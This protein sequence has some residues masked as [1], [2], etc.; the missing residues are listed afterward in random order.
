MQWSCCVFEGTVFARKWNGIAWEDMGSSSSSGMGISEATRAD[1]ICTVRDAQNRPTV[2]YNEGWLYAVTFDGAAWRELPGTAHEGGFGSGTSDAVRPTLVLDANGW[3]LVFWEQGSPAADIHG[4][5]FD[6]TAWVGLG[7]ADDTN[8]SNTAGISE[9]P[10]AALDTQ[11][12]VVLAWDEKIG[13][14]GRKVFVKRWS[15]GVW[16]ELGGSATGDGVSG[17]FNSAWRPALALLGNDQP[18]V[19]WEDESIVAKVWRDP[20]WEP[21]DGAEGDGSIAVGYA[22]TVVA[23]DATRLAFAWENPT[24]DISGVMW[25]GST[26][27][28]LSP[29][30]RDPGIL[31]TSGASTSPQLALD[32]R[33]RVVLVWSDEILHASEIHALALE[34]SGWVEWSSPDMPFGNVSGTTDASTTPVLALD[35]RRRPMVAWAD[36]ST[37]NAN[38][39]IYV[40]RYNGQRWVEVGEGSASGGGVSNSACTSAHPAIAT[41][42]GRVCVAWNECG[43]DAQ[44]V[45]LRCAT[46]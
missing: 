31:V 30:S 15:A 34:G 38:A 21:L 24:D 9:E 20:L 17:A 3:P 14:E 19:V 10:V 25:T 29:G 36:N 12:R 27:A 35:D 13:T 18:V 2:L 40:R 42:S 8:I 28:D 33:G 45:V 23:M 4:S 11:G 39:D 22:P 5:R 32:D 46:W 43:A 26:W 37:R 6:G 1:R 7:V 16:E 41:S 44:K